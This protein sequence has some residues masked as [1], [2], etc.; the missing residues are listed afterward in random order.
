[1]IRHIAVFRFKKDTT[2]EII[3]H[4]DAVVSTLPDIVDEIVAFQAGRSAGITD[5]S[6]DYG[7]VADFA[8]AE[9]YRRYAAHPDH[10]AIVE[11]DVA[12]HLIEVSRIQFC[13]QDT[14]T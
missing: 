2:E 12:P 6:W 1:M 14:P 9:D 5:T 8:S 10:V 3:D 13:I 11:N 4:I 7:V